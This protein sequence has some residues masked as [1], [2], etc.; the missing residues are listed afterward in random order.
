MNLCRSLTPW[1]GGSME[2]LPQ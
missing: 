1:T 2:Q